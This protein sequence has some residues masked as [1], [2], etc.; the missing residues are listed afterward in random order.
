[1]K[2]QAGRGLTR[3]GVVNNSVSVPMCSGLIEYMLWCLQGL[4]LQDLYGWLDGACMGGWH[5]KLTLRCEVTLVVRKLSLTLYASQVEHM[6]VSL[7][8]WSE[9]D[10]W[11]TPTRSLG[12]QFQ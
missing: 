1:V 6:S 10:V 12:P 2:G 4:T 8:V 7:S 3:M 9:R 5:F 11:A